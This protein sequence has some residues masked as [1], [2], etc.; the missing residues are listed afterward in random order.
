MAIGTFV[1]I[2]AAS[3][4]AFRGIRPEAKKLLD[5]LDGLE[6]GAVANQVELQNKFGVNRR[7]VGKLLNNFYKDKLTIGKEALSKLKKARDIAARVET[8]NIPSPISIN[9]KY[10]SAKFP[11][12]EMELEYLQ[13]IKEIRK[14]PKST[15]D[16]SNFMM[17]EKIS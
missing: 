9:R 14:L 12:K 7:I 1:R 8:P 3:P 2:M 13:D 6:P 11:T 16:M 15:S 10:V 17:A 4:R 5:H